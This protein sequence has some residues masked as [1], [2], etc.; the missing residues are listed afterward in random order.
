MVAPPLLL[1]AALYWRRLRRRDLALAGAL[2][3]GVL[4]VHV[5]WLV[6][7][8]GTHLEYVAP[9]G[10][11]KLSWRRFVEDSLQPILLDPNPAV[12]LL[13]AAGRSC[14]R[15]RCVSR[16][17]ASSC[18]SWCARLSSARP[19][20]A[21]ARPHL[22]RPRDRAHPAGRVG[23]RQAPSVRS[24]DASRRSS[25]HSWRWA[26]WQSSRST[27]TGSGA[28]TPGRSAAR[29]ARSTSCR[30]RPGSWW[31]D[32]RVDGRSGRES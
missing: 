16:M 7:L 25:I 13:G 20:A 5:H 22:R 14:F 29:P 32:P 21:R 15:G 31:L 2:V 24:A 4:L 23:C 19:S 26:W 30:T 8:L 3:G 18:G 27:W 11:A 9:A 1:G 12:L 6:G 17:G 28:S 10:V